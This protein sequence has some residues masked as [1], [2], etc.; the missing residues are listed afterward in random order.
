M[1]KDKYVVV[2]TE[3]SGLG[4]DARILEIAIASFEKG[5]I[6]SSW[7]TML[8]PLGL[9]FNDPNVKA[10]LSV[11]GFT[12][13]SL[14]DTRFREVAFE[15]YG[16]LNKET[17]VGH[18]LEFDL[19]MIAQEWTRL[20]PPAAEKLPVPNLEVCTLLSDFSLRSGF[21]K[22]NLAATCFRW[23]VELGKAHRAMADA[24]ATGK[25]LH[26]MLNELPDDEVELRELLGLAGKTWA[27]I[28]A[29]R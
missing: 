22:R 6:T 28:M 15:V 17:V 25:L 1:W 2:D 11:N 29:R 16:R 21:L 4:T 19:R 23:K 3:T 14:G 24:I 18:N 20:L 13:D 10:A 8:Y 12:P 26:A 9:D 7:S 5:E 27:E